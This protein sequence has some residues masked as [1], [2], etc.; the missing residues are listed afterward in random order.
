M[1]RI[2]VVNIDVSHPLAFSEKL[3]E[4]DK[5]RYVAVYNDGF[6]SDEEVEAF[7]RKRGLECR[8][9]TVEELA[10]MV[11]V[12]FIQGC[13]W[14]K[15]LDYVEPFMKLGKPVFID[16]PVV[17]C[18]KDIRRLE[19]LMADGLQV[20]GSSSMRYAFEVADFL[21]IP[22]EERGEI[23]HV[24]GTCGVDEFNYGIH[25]VEAI[26]AMVKNPVSVR[27]NGVG[28][29]E[30]KRTESYTVLFEDGTTADYITVTGLWLPCYF[31]VTTTK[32]VYNVNIDSSRVY[33]ALLERICEQLETGV[34]KLSPVEEILD[35]IKIM[36][37]GRI[38]R[39]RNGEVV[40]LDEIPEDDPGYDGDAFEKEYA[41]GAGPIYLQ[42]PER[43]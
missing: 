4:G 26:G 40:R 23:L 42:A 41:A 10:E 25:V 17:G 31:L 35:S 13:N 29:K 16:K 7:I 36:L 9:N 1:I 12:G 18:M 11:D 15:H 6:R 43:E 37:A 33:E 28:N 21:K 3:L 32:T 24:M 34:Q 22:V 5:A 8:C 14:D 39:E 30:G 38:S 27:F 20:L 19:K 2:G